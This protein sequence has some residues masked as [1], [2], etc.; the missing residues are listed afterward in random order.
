MNNPPCLQLDDDEDVKRPEQQIVD[1]RK[2]ARPDV[3]GVILE[4]GGPGLTRPAAS[5][6]HISLDRPFANFDAQLEQFPANALCAPQSVLSRHL[7]D[8]ADDFLG[9]R[10]FRFLVRDLRRQ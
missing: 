10:G 5:L 3:A 1:D 6:W 2:I 7:F 8:E 9:I 4:E